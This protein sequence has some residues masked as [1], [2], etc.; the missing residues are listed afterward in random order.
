MICRRARKVVTQG[1]SVVVDEIERTTLTAQGEIAVS[2][3]PGAYLGRIALEDTD[4]FFEFGVP[5][6]TGPYP[7][8]D[9]IET[10]SPFLQP[11]SLAEA[12]AARDAARA[13]AEGETAPGELGS[14]S[15][16]AWA[17]DASAS[18]AAALAHVA[19]LRE[20][21]D[22]PALLADTGLTYAPGQPGTVAAGDIARTRAEGFAYEIA[23]AGASNPHVVT[24][25]GVKLYVR[26]GPAGYHAAA[27]GVDDSGADPSVAATNTARL[28]AAI[29][30]AHA[31]GHG[32]V[33]LG[34]ATFI[35][36]VRLRPGVV[37]EGLPS[38]A[39]VADPGGFG[40]YRTG[41]GS[42]LIQVDGTDAPAI[43]HPYTDYTGGGLDG[44]DKA[45]CLGLRNIL[46]TAE[47][48]GAWALDDHPVG[49]ML[50]SC[51]FI[52]WENVF[53]Q[54]FRRNVDLQDCWDSTFIDLRTGGCDYALRIGNRGDL[55]NCN[56][57]KFFHARIESWKRNGI[58]IASGGPAPHQN[59]KI[60]FLA[61][62]NEG[63]PGVN[64]ESC[65]RV[66]GNIE[67][68]F[69]GG[70]SS[71]IRTSTP[72]PV[73]FKLIDIDA[74]TMEV[75]DL[76]FKHHGLATNGVEATL[77]SLVSI[78]PRARNI[79]SLE[80]DLTFEIA[81]GTTLTNGIFNIAP[82][83]YSA[84]DIC[85]RTIWN[86]D[87]HTLFSGLSNINQRQRRIT[88]ADRAFQHSLNI[89]SEDG[90][91]S[92]YLRREDTGTEWELRAKGDGAIGVFVD[93]SEVAAFA[94][95]GNLVMADGK[96]VTNATALG[97][98]GKTAV[99]TPPGDGA[100]VLADGV[101]WNPLG[102]S[103][104]TP[105]L[106][107]WN[108]T[109]W[110]D[111]MEIPEAAF[112]AEIGPSL[113][114]SDPTGPA[115]LF[116]SQGQTGQT[117]ELRAKADGALGVFVNDGEVATFA[118]NGN[119]VLSEG[120]AVTN[121][122][123]LGFDARA[124]ATTPP[125][126]GAL[127]LADGVLWN[128]LGRSG[129]APYLVFWNGTAWVEPVEIP[130]PVF[131][132]AVTGSL[133]ISDPT[134]AVGLLLSKEDTGTTWEL[135]AM[136][137][138]SLGVFADNGVVAE[139]TGDGDLVF[140]GDVLTSLAIRSASGPAA[141]FL[142]QT[143]TAKAWEFRCKNDGGLGLFVN[144]EQ[145]LSV[146]PNGNLVFEADKL[147]VADAVAL[148]HQSAPPPTPAGTLVLAAA[149]RTTWDPAGKGAG[150]PYLVAWTGTA[151]TEV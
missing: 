39:D 88:R 135:R 111:L 43:H 109:G 106:A 115:A 81:P 70:Y 17:G 97:F 114:I 112:P 54:N 30:A 63:H 98:D 11:P 27:F 137:S 71:I 55:D 42:H 47:T 132:N 84:V 121:L 69:W 19:G 150:G 4:R 91:A 122:A 66:D 26:P 123:A 41:P 116:L 53:V 56:N 20:V 68:R 139:F 105:Y 107:F 45:R 87:D 99:F 58:E 2:L 48:P 21:R 145:V 60:E 140:G 131:P 149:D 144:D 22:V 46:V 18:A 141:L 52:V 44:G 108:G 33:Y 127:A 12:Q 126:D 117:W 119:M 5:E 34:R 113:T 57:L 89:R 138:G 72:P 151:W 37:L 25:S 104:T 29:D 86:P 64:G 8:E 118:A 51:V 14:R 100:L 28:Q 136:N 9:G 78:N 7:I 142:S 10:A 38:S 15:S 6:G 79:R 124:A 94:A 40:G 76:A 65:I 83:A 110:A 77:D 103:E 120:K 16:K 35:T 59:N 143:A 129:S 36:S 93:N 3:L 146:A 85:V 24:G 23:E 130:E 73:G 32:A 90:P 128:P 148:R 125:G 1:G 95:N 102:R 31:S 133:T 67:C 62:K 92:L 13:W 82:G 147:P 80:L 75:V 49:V 96:S 134:S 50:A 61:L 101:L 74:G